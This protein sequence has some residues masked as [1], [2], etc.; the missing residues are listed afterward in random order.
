MTEPLPKPTGLE[1][2][3]PD[4]SSPGNEKTV[5]VVTSDGPGLIRPPVVTG[6]E[7]HHAV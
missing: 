7:N 1:S 2:S 3:A 4:P 6:R 5:G